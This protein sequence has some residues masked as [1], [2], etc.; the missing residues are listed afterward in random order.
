MKNLKHV[1]LAVLLFVSLLTV[2]VGLGINAFSDNSPEMLTYEI[3][4]EKVIIK[5]CDASATEVVI[6][7][8][9][10]D[11]PVTAISEDAFADCTALTDV[12]F[13]G[14]ADAW[15]SFEVEVG[16]GVRLHCNVEDAASH[17][18]AGKTVSP[19]CIAKGYTEY[20]CACGYEKNSDYVDIDPTGHSYMQTVD[21]AATCMSMGTT[22][23][24]CS[25]CGATYT[26]NNLEIDPENHTGKTELRNAVKE[27][28]GAEGYT[29]DTY[30]ECGELLEE[31][32]VIPATGNHAYDSEN[33][34]VVKEATCSETGKRL[35]TCSVCGDNKSFDID[36]DLLNHVGGT[37]LEGKKDPT[38]VE[39]GYT[40]DTHCSSCKTKIV[41]G[42]VIDKIPHNY[43]NE[44]TTVPTCCEKG[45][46][47][48]TCT[49]CD[50]SYTEEINFDAENH[51]EY[52]TE[53]RDAVEVTC[54]ADGFSGNIHCLGCEIKLED[55]EVIPATGNHDFDSEVTKTPDCKET[56]VKTYTCKVCDHVKTEVLAKDATNHA[57]YETE[58]RGAKAETCVEN[59]YTGDVCCTGCDA[60]LESGE[61]KSAT[62]VH[63]YVSAVTK[64]ANCHETGV[65]TSI[66]STCGGFTTEEIAKDAENHVGET[67]IRDAVEEDCGNDGFSGDTYCL[68]C[69]EKIADGA[70]INA[71]GNHNY[72]SEITV[73]A[74][75]IAK[76][77]KTFTCTVCKDSYKEPIDIDAENHVG[78]TEV[79][80]DFAEDCGNDGYTGDTYCLDCENVIEEG[81]KIPATGEHTYKSEVTKTPDC[82]ETGE[83][84]FTCTVCGYIKTEE[85]AKDAENHA[86]Y[87]TELRDV[88]T[89][90]C[91][92]K[93]YTGDTYCLGCETKIAVGEETPI[94]GEHVYITATT[95]DANC[96]EEGV[97]THICSICN[98]FYTDSI[99]INPLNH[100]GGTEIR[101]DFAPTCVDKGYSG[102]LYCSG[103][104]VKLRNGEEIDATGVHTYESKV[105]TEPTCCSTGVRTYTCTVETCKDTYTETIAKNPA[106]HA[107][108]TEIRGYVAEDCGN[109]GY[110]G[111]TYCLGCNT[112]TKSGYT[113]SATGKHDYKYDTT[114]APTCIE[115]GVK[116]I[117]CSVCDYFETEEIAI[118]KNNHADYGTEIRDAADA[119]CGAEGFTGDTYCKGCETILV[120]GDPIPA[121]GKHT[122][123]HIILT[124]PT[125]IKKGLKKV[126]CT[127]CADSRTESL[128]T[129]PENHA[130]ETE[131][132]DAVAETCGEDGYSG[133]T[134]CLDCKEKISDGEKIDATGEHTFTEELTKIPT[135]C[136][137]GEMTYTCSV[138][139]H[140]ETE[141]VE[142]DAENHV[143]ETEIRDDFAPTC[144][145]KG[146]TGN[147]YC[148]SCDTILEEGEEIPEETDMHIYIGAVTTE[149]TCCSKGVRTFT[150]EIC[151]DSFTEEIAIN[152]DKHTGETEI[153]DAKNATCAATGYTGDTYCKGCNKKIANGTEIKK[154]AHTEVK[155]EGKPATCSEAGKTD[156]TICSVCATVI[157]AQKTIAKLDHN[158]SEWTLVKE[159]TVTE[160]GSEERV[161]SV[162][163]KKETRSVEKLSFIVGDV[164]GDG[165]ITAADA[166]IVL[167]ISAK[168]V[169]AEDYNLP[170]EAFDMNGDGN[171][172][173]A[174]ARLILRKSAKLED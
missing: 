36:I 12:Y 14:A 156:G 139:D 29:G 104:G 66:C 108:G 115:K 149:A 52:G 125:C 126:A 158:Y 33:G 10:N 111:D 141:D 107:G 167:R 162:C 75:C 153:R 27:T 50:D 82:K 143:G 131:I 7:A 174:D 43:S 166:R 173:A 74:T 89:S 46:K 85:I 68:G 146:Y 38:C 9:I 123:E 100:A 83:M 96:H 91:G 47:T 105:T 55:G 132:R 22:K 49:E 20:T 134:Y 40:G 48:F 137:L 106:N 113:I 58:L 151:N 120:Y 90:N 154:T 39:T 16:E 145:T 6:P 44:V 77:E 101:D 37:T 95:K 72:E 170:L 31:G 102:D 41:T 117:T 147:L 26:E 144:I 8:E 148:T 110:S 65:K 54:G 53:V 127:G 124:A 87:D 28:C 21:N 69:K 130:G 71:T 4:E 155:V 11:L 136:E 114:V 73:P 138:C 128:V 18:V 17:W 112:M 1:C 60:V 51:A 99:E 172:T 157:V 42:V 163:D 76:G 165:K 34:I 45:V 109:D 171:L 61:V 150:C 92:R 5:K 30:C 59:G 24:S 169:K 35:D 116:T 64:V 67:E 118:D 15:T 122:Y 57:D 140:V 103:C 160:E 2:M 93:G 86:E 84:T 3:V 80:D 159:P 129:D 121:T 23:H 97:I 164:N 161:C 56:G 79:R 142:L 152:A 119:T 135:C 13:A 32:E 25:Y 133:D 98:H 63:A 94:S 168:I 81:S 62:G 78:E 88:V 19:T 70:V